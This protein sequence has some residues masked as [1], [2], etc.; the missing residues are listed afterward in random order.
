MKR[1]PRITKAKAE[2]PEQKA[3]R[4][5]VEKIANN[6]ASLAEAVESLLNGPLKRRALVVL[7]AVSSK[8]PQTVVDDVLRALASLKGDW[9]NK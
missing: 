2:T 9:L 7:L 3:Y 8:Q 4:E 6:I 1:I 5:T